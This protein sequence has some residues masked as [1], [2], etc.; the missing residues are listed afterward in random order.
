[1]E[2]RLKQG[3][4]EPPLSDELAHHYAEYWV[5]QVLKDEG[6]YSLADVDVRKRNGIIARARRKGHEAFVAATDRIQ[7]MS[8]AEERTSKRRQ[9]FLFTDPELVEI[10]PATASC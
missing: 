10:P 3:E 4:I 2:N 5:H 7:E 9:P 1:M 6:L 8:F